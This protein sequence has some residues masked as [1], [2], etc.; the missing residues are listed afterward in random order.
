[1]AAKI[2]SI[3]VVIDGLRDAPDL[4]ICFEYDGFYI[5]A[6][7]QFERGGQS[8]GPGAR[9]H[10]YFFFRVFVRHN[11]FPSAPTVV[12]IPILPC[13]LA[14][15]TKRVKPDSFRGNDKTEPGVTA[16]LN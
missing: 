7:Q 12:E 9:D 10:G 1:M 6:A 11:L 14:R 5:R 3:A 13:A 2:H 16:D 4:S 8:R 15:V